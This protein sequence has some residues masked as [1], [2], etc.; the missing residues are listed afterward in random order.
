MSIIKAYSK[1]DPIKTW[2]KRP[3]YDRFNAP[4]HFA[5]FFFQKATKNE[6]NFL[7]KILF[8]QFDQIIFPTDYWCCKNANIAIICFRVL[9][10]YGTENSNWKFIIFLRSLRNELV[11]NPVRLFLFYGLKISPLVT[12]QRNRVYSVLVFCVGWSV[13]SY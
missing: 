8:F 9:V 1:N 3:W 7:K 10:K 6:G 12:R 13:L 11:L 2:V 5:I 4:S